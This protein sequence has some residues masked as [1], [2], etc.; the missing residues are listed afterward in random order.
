MCQVCRSREKT[1]TAHPDDM[2]AHTHKHK[3]DIKEVKIGKRRMGFACH[4]SGHS[5]A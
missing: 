1:R 5:F 4:T 3:E 2:N